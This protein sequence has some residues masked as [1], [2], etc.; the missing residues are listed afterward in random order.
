MSRSIGTLGRLRRSFHVNTTAV[1]PESAVVPSSPVNPQ[2]LAQVYKLPKLTASSELKLDV[3]GDPASAASLLLPPSL[4]VHIRRGSL[5]ALQGNPNNVSMTPKYLNAAK[6]LLY[7]NLSSRYTLVVS[8]ETI[9]MLVSSR[10]DTAIPR[11]FRNTTLRSFASI[12]LDGK[13]DWALI[14]RDALHV[15]GGPSLIVETLQIPQK[16]SR[17]LAKT[18]GMR[19][20][21]NTGLFSWW[22]P[23][24]TFV[25]GRGVIGVVGNGLVYSVD[26]AEGEEFAVNKSCLVGF[27]VNGPK[28]IQNIAVQHEQP[29]KYVPAVIMPPPKVARMQT[30]TDVLINIKHYS[31]LAAKALKDLWLLIRRHFSETPGFIRIIGPRTVLIQSGDPLN[32]YERS[33]QLAS[34]ESYGTPVPVKEE[35]VPRVAEDYLNTVT[36]GPQGTTIESTNS[37]VKK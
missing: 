27:S 32:K 11:L 12:T 25:G 8:T 29:P 21:T 24:Y 26:V 7:G 1:P 23:G 33:F 30:R 13:Y 17:Q 16:I 37:F 3:F 15:Y 6:R 18:L 34:L 28:D 22:K 35:P 4:S 2:N 36:V 19:T 10:A 5:L 14:K 9:Q 31:W 20:R